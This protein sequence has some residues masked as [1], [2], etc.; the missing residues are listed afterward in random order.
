MFV[1]SSLVMVMRIEF[2]G[3]P[4]VAPD[5]GIVV[6]AI[7]DGQEVICHFQREVLQHMN[8]ASVTPSAQEAFQARA[9]ALLEI[10]QRKIRSGGY[11]SGKTVITAADI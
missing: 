3:S 2:I 1:A 9:S 5:K 10:V 11:R 8:G 4:R 7:V 6:D